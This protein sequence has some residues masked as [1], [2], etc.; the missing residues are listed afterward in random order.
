MRP[1]PLSADSLLLA[2]IWVSPA[3]PQSSAPVNPVRPRTIVTADPELDD[4]NSL[5]RFLLYSTDVQTE[6]LIYARSASLSAKSLIESRLIEAVAARTHAGSDAGQT[7]ALLPLRVLE[8]D[9]TLAY[10][11]E[12]TL[13][14]SLPSTLSQLLERCFFRTTI[15]R[16]ADFFPDLTVEQ[17][18]ATNRVG[19]AC[20]SQADVRRVGA[21]ASHEP[22]VQE[23][24]YPTPAF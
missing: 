20:G 10:D 16:C 11:V 9:S 7:T 4:S 19:A 8:P 24:L 23:E 17:T 13:H 21:S 5:V 6:G 15:V 12:K 22:L 14:E 18:T 2:L 1:A 3:W